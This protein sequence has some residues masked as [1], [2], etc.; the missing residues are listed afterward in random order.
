MFM[1]KIDPMESQR[2][3]MQVL[4]KIRKHNVLP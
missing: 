4:S 3:P 1:K 2:L